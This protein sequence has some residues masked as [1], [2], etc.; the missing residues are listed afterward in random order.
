MEVEA[1]DGAD[2]AVPSLDEVGAVGVAEDDEVGGGVGLG[3]EDSSDQLVGA[4]AAGGLVEEGGV[5]DLFEGGVG[6]EALEGGELEVGFGE[7]GFD[8]EVAEA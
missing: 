5:E 2:D 3:G 7:L 8:E 1:A 4:D 6:L